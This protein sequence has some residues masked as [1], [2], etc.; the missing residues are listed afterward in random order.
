MLIAGNELN[1]LLSLP[2]KYFTISI[3]AVTFAFCNFYVSVSSNKFQNV[4]I[5]NT[6]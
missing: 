4:I 6:I 2:L 5:H 3:I 1:L